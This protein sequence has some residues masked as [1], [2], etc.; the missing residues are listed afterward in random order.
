[1]KKGVLE[2]TMDKAMAI[3]FVV[4]ALIFFIMVFSSYSMYTSNMDQLVENIYNPGNRLEQDSSFE[5]LIDEKG[6]III[7]GEVF[8]PDKKANELSLMDYAMLGWKL[9]NREIINLGNKDDSIF[10]YNYII[11]ISCVLYLFIISSSVTS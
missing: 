1:M 7:D 6:N 5:Q 3:M 11:I 9:F 2:N 8:V 4:L 10:N